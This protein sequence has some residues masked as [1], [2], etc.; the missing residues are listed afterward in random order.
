LRGFGSDHFALFSEL[1]LEDGRGEQQS[2]LKANE[3]DLAWAND[4][5]DNKG[6]SKKD[7][8]PLETD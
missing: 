5:A 1:V 2:S 6:V 4:K 7:V 8:P 3:D